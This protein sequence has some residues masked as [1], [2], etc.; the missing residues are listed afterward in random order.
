MCTWFAALARAWRETIKVVNIA[1]KSL[2][3]SFRSLP[4]LRLLLPSLV[5]G[6]TFAALGCHAQAVSP[7]GSAAAGTTT[8]TPEMARRVEVLIRAKSNVPAN[9]QIQIGPKTKSDV[10]GY[11]QISVGF[12]AD[13]KASKPLNFLLSTDGKTLA[14]FNKFD[15]SQDPK[16]LVSAVGRPARGGPESAPVLIVG[17]DD[18][19]CPFCA[20]MNAQL[21]PALLERYKNQ[22]RIV[23]RDFPLDQHPWAMRAAVDVNCVA[24]QSGTGYWNLIDYIH[25][26]ANEI[27]G[28]QKT[29]AKANEMLDQLARD[30]GKKEGLKADVLDAC[31]AKQDQSVVKS[32][33]KEAEA[34]GVEST[35][36]LFI[37]GEKLE[38]AVPM[39]YV[40]RMIDGALVAEGQTP[41]AAAVSAAA[42][43]ARPAG[44]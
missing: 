11:E 40:Y 10:P 36:A 2:R 21:F 9:Y 27:G 23:Y 43:A 34:L 7:A 41:P 44:N 22:V 24:A 12:S 19:E 28:D 25:A 16:A 1:L 26:H 39:E 33:M 30:E 18:L 35:P 5:V 8:L 37:N 17:F 42:P 6:L 4:S 13:G 29:I 20:K 14:Q 38:G 15:I 3:S 32:S 31:L